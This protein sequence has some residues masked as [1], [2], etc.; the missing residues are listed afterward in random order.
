LGKGKG[1]TEKAEKN[2]WCCPDNMLRI[3][4]M[5]K[6]KPGGK[7]MEARK[8]NKGKKKMH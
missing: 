1:R 6:E 5:Q 7:G 4:K 3:R 2:A 8:K